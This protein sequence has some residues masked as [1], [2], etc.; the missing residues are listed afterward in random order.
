MAKKKKV[1]E[2]EVIAEEK[3]EPEVKSVSS[4]ELETVQDIAREKALQAKI[5]AGGS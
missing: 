4:P 5:R 3:I 1:I 2:E